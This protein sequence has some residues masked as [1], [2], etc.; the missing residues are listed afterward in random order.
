VKRKPTERSQ[1]AQLQL[2]A[3]TADK[4][5]TGAVISRDGKYVAYSDK[6][7]I[8]IQEIENGESHK[9]PGTVGLELQDWYPDGLHLLVTD[10][11]DLWT[12]FAFSG[13]KHKLASHVVG[14]GISPDGSQI[15]FFS[16]VAVGRTVDHACHRRRGAGAVFSRPRRDLHC[17]RLV[18]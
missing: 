1:I 9:L 10:G 8:S 2:T 3:R 4:P 6:D 16:R 11:K 7:G 14:A 17:R 13:E 15:L 12:L 18:P 5:V